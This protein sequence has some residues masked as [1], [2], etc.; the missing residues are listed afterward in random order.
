MNTTKSLFVAVAAVTLACAA[1]DQGEKDAGASQQQPAA[2]PAPPPK[3]TTAPTPTPSPVATAVQP[4]EKPTAEFKIAAVANTM[5]F[6]VTSFTVSA[7]QK[8]HVVLTNNASI[9]LPHNWVLVKPKS[10]AAVAAAGI[11][12]GEAGGYL[13]TSNE[14]VLAYTPMAKD[15]GGTSEVTFTAPTT[16]G[17]Y[18]YICT[19]PGH[20]L[21]MKGV[22]TVQ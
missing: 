9:R 11:P 7:G 4:M 3:A 14:N 22:L 5:T 8:V 1:C 12:K 18:P 19:V 6:D 21:K 20:Y 13:D 10:E 2:Q 17:D 15:H 16:P